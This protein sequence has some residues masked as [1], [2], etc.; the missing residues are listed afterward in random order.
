MEGLG[1]VDVDSHSLALKTF[2]KFSPSHLPPVN[3]CSSVSYSVPWPL[4]SFQIR[5]KG[6]MH[7]VARLCQSFPNNVRTRTVYVPFFC[8]GIFDRG[9]LYAVVFF[10]MCGLLTAVYKT[11]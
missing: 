8:L 1:S 3:D 6:V 11:E 7:C 2:C 5:R 9:L 4:V 10:R